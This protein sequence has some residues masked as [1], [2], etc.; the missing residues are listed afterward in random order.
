MT[1][2]ELRAE[3]ARV[4]FLFARMIES[5][6]PS[7]DDAPATPRRPRRPKRATADAATPPSDLDSARARAALRRAGV[8]P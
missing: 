7:D 3:L 1:R 2:A 4:L 6:P 8:K 5:L